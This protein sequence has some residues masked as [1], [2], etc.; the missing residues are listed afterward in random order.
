MRDQATAIRGSH[1][2]NM[3]LYIAILNTFPLNPHGTSKKLLSLTNKTCDDGI[4]TIRLE[5]NNWKI[6]IFVL[7]YSFNRKKDWFKKDS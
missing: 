3:A 7:I 1:T 6:T 4:S 2:P 5:Q